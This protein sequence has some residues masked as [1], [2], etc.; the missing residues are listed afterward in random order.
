MGF[1]FASII[2]LHISQ[3]T[4]FNVRLYTHLSRLIFL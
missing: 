3:C 4:A 1:K 2:A